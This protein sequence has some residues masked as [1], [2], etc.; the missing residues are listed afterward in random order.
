MA[1]LSFF[2]NSVEWA[3][4]LIAVSIRKILC[5]SGLLGAKTW[6]VNVPGSVSPSLVKAYRQVVPSA[7]GIGHSARVTDAPIII[8]NRM[9][10]NRDTKHANRALHNGQGARWPH[11]QD[12]RATVSCG[13]RPFRQCGSV[14]QVWLAD[15]LALG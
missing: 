10:Q 8:Q 12:G 9:A 3:M 5:S 2:K 6:R 11:S 7:V 15:E 13:G 1:L 4:P 14:G